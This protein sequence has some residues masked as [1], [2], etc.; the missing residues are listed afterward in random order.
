MDPGA[1][2]RAVAAAVT[3]PAPHHTTL[4]LRPPRVRRDPHP[5]AR[6]DARRVDR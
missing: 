4:A 5:S 3:A 2:R 1:V 6:R